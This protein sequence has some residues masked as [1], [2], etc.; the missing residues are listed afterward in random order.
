MEFYSAFLTLMG[1]APLIHMHPCF[2]RCF[3][4]VETIF[5]FFWIKLLQIKIRIVWHLLLYRTYV[6]RYISMFRIGLL[7][8][9]ANHTEPTL[10]GIYNKLAKRNIH[11]C[12]DQ[13][14]EWLTSEEDRTY[15]KELLLTSINGYIDIMANQHAELAFFVN[16]P[17]HL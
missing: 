14:Y 7:Y 4:Y 3:L 9:H 8:L 17:I 6:C 15:D 12:C 5:K 1:F 10:Y 16:L 2:T 11:I 13:L